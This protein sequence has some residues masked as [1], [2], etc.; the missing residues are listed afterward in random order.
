MATEL[1]PDGRISV[2]TL[3]S[4]EELEALTVGGAR[5]Q[6][7]GKD[8]VYIPE[9]RRSVLAD[10]R[11]GS[12]PHCSEHEDVLSEFLPAGSEEMKEFLSTRKVV[13]FPDRY[14]DGGEI[15]VT[16][17]IL[18][19]IQQ[20]VE[21][22]GHAVLPGR[23]RKIQLAQ[24][25]TDV[26]LQVS[27]KLPRHVVLSARAMAV[28]EPDVASARLQRFVRD[29]GFPDISVVSGTYSRSKLWARQSIE[30]LAATV[31]PSSV[32]ISAEVIG[33]T[34][35]LYA[36][37]GTHGTT[38][39]WHVAGPLLAAQQ[40]YQLHKLV[41]ARGPVVVALALEAELG[42]LN[43]DIANGNSYAIPR[44][45][46]HTGSVDIKLPPASSPITMEMLS[47]TGHVALK[48]MTSMIDEVC[49]LGRPVASSVRVSAKY[50]LVNDHVFRA[51]DV[52]LD[53]QTVIQER[54]IS[55]DVWLVK[56]TNF[57]GTVAWP[58]R[59]PREGEE[60]IVCYRAPSGLQVTSP[61]TIRMTDGKTM[62]MSLVSDLVPGM[63]GGAVVAMSDMALLGVYEGI[64]AQVAVATVFSQETFADIHMAEVSSAASRESAADADDS[65]YRKLKSRGL[66]RYIDVAMSSIQPLFS[67]GVHVGLG[68]VNGGNLYTTCDPGVQPLSLGE[69]GLPLVFESTIDF[70]YRAKVGE[71]GIPGPMLYRKPS[72]FEKVV[73]VGRDSEGPYYSSTTRV[74]HVGV[75]SKNFSLEGFSED[76]ALPFVG[77]L[78]IA[79][80]DSSVLGQFVRRSNSEVLGDS[81]FCVNVATEHVGLGSPKL[82][83][84]VDLALVVS[85]AFPMLNT[86]IW[87]EK[88]LEEVFTH[89]SAQRYKSQQLFNT[90]LSPLAYVGDSAFKL[91]MGIQLR[92][93]AVPYTRWQSVI[94]RVQ[95]NV[96]LAEVCVE[97]GLASGL[98]LGPG[99]QR[100]PDSSKVY[101][102]LLEALAGAVYLTE[103]FETFREFCDAV[104]VVV[105]VRDS[106]IGL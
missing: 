56:R 52:T 53:G 43:L 17:N 75:G 95:S 6:F 32:A 106:P 84:E 60:V 49:V 12:L 82:A 48:E 31:S 83:V 34:L 76:D 50:S 40:V 61:M 87:D 41:A 55:K 27:L 71:L 21:G 96:V 28:S 11:F 16:S 93:L 58:L 9:I 98:V 89:S 24:L 25:L 2:H 67:R 70:R 3:R 104:G 14:G 101:A 23:Q 30:K 1:L 7:V 42:I 57:V 100:P 91:A 102:D 19:K 10:V 88:L 65:V 54:M 92:S 39:S 36:D 46:Y 81:Q 8:V 99:V 51:G 97:R 62:S 90:G 68:Y 94:Q 35:I 73:I 86:G 105:G 74:V 79:L 63:S 38:R 5:V 45:T 80:T 15:R 26:D 64:G 66:G 29:V 4:P 47:S 72:Y 22:T 77:G 85:R 78:V 18:D 59:S 20:D 37:D 13:E 44:I 69:G 33:V 103:T